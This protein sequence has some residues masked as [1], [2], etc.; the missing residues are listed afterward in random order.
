MLSDPCLTLSDPHSK[1]FK[2]VGG[3]ALRTIRPSFPRFKIAEGSARRTMYNKLW[4][5]DSDILISYV[6]QNSCE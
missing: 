6:A 2:I 3:C 5:A 1:R 4:H